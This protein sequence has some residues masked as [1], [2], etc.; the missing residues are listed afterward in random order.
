MHWEER[1]VS[2]VLL[3]AKS[4]GDLYLK[5]ERALLGLTLGTMNRLTRLAAYHFFQEASLHAHG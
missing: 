2:Y 4:M 1:S 5:F 3:D